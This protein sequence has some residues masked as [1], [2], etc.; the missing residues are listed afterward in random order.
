MANFTTNVIYDNFER[1]IVQF[2]HFAT[3][4]LPAFG[5][6]ATI[7]ASSLT[8]YDSSLSATSSN[9]NINVSK[10][11]WSLPQGVT[12]TGVELAWGVSGSITGSPFMYLNNTGR[13]NF[14]ADGIPQRN[15]STAATRINTFQIR[16][17]NAINTNDSMTITVELDKNGGYVRQM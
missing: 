15:T 8:G 3:G 7:A 17:T 9:I 1:S 12:A 2:T 13:W 10:V 6:T 5:L 16:N 4:G 11:Y 14:A